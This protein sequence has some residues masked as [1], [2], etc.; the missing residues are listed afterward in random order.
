MIK[1]KKLL[2][3]ILFLDLFDKFLAGWLYFYLKS[4][5]NF[6]IDGTE[7]IRSKIAICFSK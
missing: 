6:A 2:L 3:K 1:D 5:A 4:L 7:L